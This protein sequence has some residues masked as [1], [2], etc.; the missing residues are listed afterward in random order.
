MEKC[1]FPQ[2]I[3][4]KRTLII[5]PGRMLDNNNAHDMVGTITEAQG[6]GFNYIIL[7]MA[8][9]EFISSAGVGSI[10]GT[11]EISRESGGD[12][13][14]CNVSRTIRHIF[15]VLDLVDYL[16]IQD[17]LTQA[18]ELCDANSSRRYDT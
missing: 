16:N 5:N 4:N 7:D 8:E 9:L 6:S 11:I 17:D 14:L 10:L 13:V 2:N 18:K 15:K 3:V 1:T 12:I